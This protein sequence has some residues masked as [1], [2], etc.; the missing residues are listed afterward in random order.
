MLQPLKSSIIH[1]GFTIRR[2]TYRVLKTGCGRRRLR[3]LAPPALHRTTRGGLVS[4]FLPHTQ[5]ACFFFFPF[6]G[7]SSLGGHCRD[8]GAS[9]SLRFLPPP[10]SEQ[11]RCVTICQTLD[12]HAFRTAASPTP[13]TAPNEPGV[14]RERETGKSKRTD[15]LCLNPGATT[16]STWSSVRVTFICWV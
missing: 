6:P 4:R 5:L 9:R 14:W 11:P 7:V 8:S 15:L 10:S 3:L 16:T 13:R 2:H 12:G 1:P